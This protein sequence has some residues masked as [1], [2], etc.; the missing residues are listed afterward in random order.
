MQI[1]S[2]KAVLLFVDLVTG[3]TRNAIGGG[4]K[5]VKTIKFDHEP[6]EKA[7]ETFPKHALT[8]QLMVCYLLA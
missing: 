7:G 2:T 1:R 4:E 8:L 6:A 5:I 3:F